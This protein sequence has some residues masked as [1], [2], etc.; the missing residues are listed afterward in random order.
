M[1]PLHFPCSLQRNEIR[2]Q[3]LPSWAFA[4]TLEAALV[5]CVGLFQ[6]QINAQWR[7]DFCLRLKAHPP[8]QAPSTQG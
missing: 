8:S 7:R 1:L 3:R 5:K 4:R 2:Q 6:G